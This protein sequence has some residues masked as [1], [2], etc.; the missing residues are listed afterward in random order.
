MKKLSRKQKKEQK[1]ERASLFFYLNGKLRTVT[2]LHN[3]S[4]GREV[5]VWLRS[6]KSDLRTIAKDEIDGVR[7]STVF[8]GVNHR[9]SFFGSKGK[10]LLFETMTFGDDNGICRRYSSPKQARRGHKEVVEWVM[11][12]GRG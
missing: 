6:Q 4:S 9:F 3:R 5:K 11:S 7:I 1:K 10:P 12:N 2:F 8:L